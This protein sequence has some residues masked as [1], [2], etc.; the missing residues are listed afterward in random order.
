MQEVFKR[1]GDY[2]D[3]RVEKGYRIITLTAEGYLKSYA[4]EAWRL[5]EIG[6]VVEAGIGNGWA[7]PNTVNEIH[8]LF[9][10]PEMQCKF[11]WLVTSFRAAEEISW[12]TLRNLKDYFSEQL[13]LCNGTEAMSVFKGGVSQASKL[14]SFVGVIGKWFVYF[15]FMRA[16]KREVD[17]AMKGKGVMLYTDLADFSES[18]RELLGIPKGPDVLQV[19]PGC[20]TSF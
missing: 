15:L 5:V 20:L 11:C 7:G 17:A 12:D 19:R 6:A 18:L 1:L 2:Y 8:A 9:P 4:P 10:E 3:L 16:F 13:P 14:L